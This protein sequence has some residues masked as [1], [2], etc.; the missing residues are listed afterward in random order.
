[1]NE[2]HISPSFVAVA[3]AAKEHVEAAR[4]FDAKGLRAVESATGIGALVATMHEFVESRV[5]LESACLA[6]QDMNN[7]CDGEHKARVGNAGVIE[8]LTVAMKRHTKSVKLQLLGCSI[9]R[10]LTRSNDENKARAQDAGAVEAV[11]AAMRTHAMQ[12]KVQEVACLTLYNITDIHGKSQASVLLGNAGAVEAVV[13]AMRTHVTDAEVQVNAC[14]ALSSITSE[15][16]NH[17]RAQNAGAIEAMVAAMRER[18]DD[19][20]VQLHGCA[21]LREMTSKTYENSASFLRLLTRDQYVAAIDAMLAAMRAYSDGDVHE[22]ACLA[23]SQLTC[24][25]AVDHV[26]RISQAVKAGAVETLVATLLTHAQKTQ[27]AQEDACALIVSMT[28]NN[29]GT[30]AR[31]VHA[32]AV[33]A[34]VALLCAQAGS[35]GLV[36][37]ESACKALTSMLTYLNANEVQAWAGSAGA[38]GALTAVLLAHK[39]SELVR[40]HVCK[41]MYMITDGHAENLTRALNVDAIEAVVIAMRADAEDSEM[42]EHACRALCSMTSLHSRGDGMSWMIPAPASIKSKKDVPR[43]GSFSEHLAI[44]SMGGRHTPASI[45]SLVTSL[46]IRAGKAGAIEAVVAALRT[47]RGHPDVPALMCLAL[48]C[49]TRGN[50]ANAARAGN[51]GAIEAIVEA[52]ETDPEDELLQEG[53]CRLLHDLLRFDSANQIRTEKTDA[54]EFVVC[55]MVTYAGS[56]GLQHQACRVLHVLTSK[57]PQNKIRAGRE[58]AVEAVVAALRRHTKIQAVQLHAC[59]ALRALTSD[60]AARNQR[61]AMKAHAFEAVIA[62]MRAHE[63]LW[64][65]QG[66]ACR[67]LRNMTQ[68]RRPDKNAEQ[69]SPT[70]VLRSLRQ[71]DHLWARS[72]HAIDA[73]VAAMRTHKGLEEVQVRACAALCNLTARNVE[74][75]NTRAVN[76]GAIEAV[77]EAMRTHLPSEQVQERAC[78]VLRNLTSSIAGNMDRAKDAG[79][80]EAVL[81][82]M[83]GHAASCRVQTQTCVAL[84]NLT[85]GNAVNTAH[86]GNAKGVEAVVAAQRRHP[87]SE[88]VQESACAALYF[89]TNGNALNK[90][91]ALKAGAKQCAEAALRTHRGHAKVVEEARDLLHLLS[92]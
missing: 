87:M 46:Q 48:E 85:A 43:G 82:A 8:A 24:T 51:V 30:T 6:V 76:A 91:R 49:M 28:D 26:E 68:E 74:R 78:G 21:L 20:D 86:A 16:E 37:L 52:A 62:A 1:M 70:H 9:L 4:E 79:A 77:V 38:I 7:E 66:E 59:A 54:I 60:V 14:L 53:A 35:E 33:E 67:A 34:V 88:G 45:I 41:L 61:R 58:G 81:M 55:A 84:R 22:A 32:G 42:L 63:G 56:E 80:L 73:V 92:L 50:S 5:V 64:E 83:H 40:E 25:S 23:L 65:L 69:K 12:A 2:G 75:H 3:K 10:N 90:S 44:E 29:E 71:E 72:N 13:A 17:T 19:E 47:R 27:E 11:V 89:L 39:G 57:H 36:Q 15:A 18:L 31:T